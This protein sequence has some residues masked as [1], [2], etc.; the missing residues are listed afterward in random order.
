MFHCPCPGQM[1][2]LADKEGKVEDMPV[3][4]SPVATMIL[5]ALAG[6][7]AAVAVLLL[8]VR[9]PSLGM[10]LVAADTPNAVQ[11]AALS[12]KGPAQGEVA[13]GR[14]I[15]L[16]TAGLPEF[17]LLP[18]DLTDEPDTL[19]TYAAMADFFARQ[20]RIADALKQDRILVSTVDAQGV[21]HSSSLSP[22]PI[23]PVRDLPA[24]FWV[25]LLVGFASYLIGM[26][27]W[28]L[29]PGD[30]ATGLFALASFGILGFTFPA[31]LYSTRE[32]ALDGTFF[33]VLST[34]N[35]G[36]ALLFGAAM[37]ALLLRY[38]RPL[39]TGRWLTLPF[40][41][42]GLWWLA[43]TLRL[44][45]GPP[46]GAHL[47]TL[48]EMGGI[49]LCAGLQYWN[50]R[51]DPGARTVLRW[52]GLSVLV[53]A[54]GFVLT[55]IAP[56]MVGFAPLLPQ[57]YAFT[58][59]LLIHIG[60]A[61]GVVRYRLFDLDRWA[62]HILFYMVG[63][64]LLILLDAAL[65][66]LVSVGRAPAFGL[67]LLA[68]GLFYLPLRDS[69]ARRLSGRR[70]EDRE[71]WFQAMI[72]VAL[73]PSPNTQ[74]LRWRGLLETVFEP[75]R[76]FPGDDHAAPMLRDEGMALAMPAIGSL[77]PL[78]LEH[79]RKGR[80]LFTPYELGLAS[81]L[82]AMLIHAIGSRDAYERGVA[83]ERGRITRD[84]H[85]NI[86]VHLLGALHSQ[87]VERKDKLIRE[88]LGDL[89]DIINNSSGP[90]LTLEEHMADLRVEIADLL[91][92]AGIGFDWQFDLEGTDAFPAQAV[93]TLRAILREGVGNALRHAGASTIR[94]ALRHEG[95][96]TTLTIEDDGR[97]FDPATIIPG[98]GLNN[99][100]VRMAGLE[101]HVT[102][103]DAAP[104]TRIEARFP[105]EER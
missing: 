74:H 62:F 16:Q 49:L 94:I 79:A 10:E 58:F 73:T 98:N 104:G 12:P 88:T 20:S 35:H 9:Q 55:V 29:R 34:M 76:I 72:D 37:I 28:R 99:M 52:F 60:L 69:I 46:A 23:R 31:A 84:M 61:F 27:V 54:G 18:A 90:H 53:G 95:D 24:A 44:F 87:N 100:R 15:S 19:P 8:A 89:R 13:P 96:F 43:D 41:L 25:Q 50:A 6:L 1:A 68:I 4:L 80:R 63:A 51:G 2:V 86:G 30:P 36:G 64:V 47:P 56:S 48:I 42:F 82:H 97:G 103:T 70:A 83:E 3:R 66:S 81:E 22:A 101:G 32:L 33:R 5:L 71:K 57:G 17:I 93:P 59:F 75:L 7:A 26:W 105:L 91:S 14:L 102:I 67:S 78:R 85:D 38:P 11:V 21:A 45:D 92:S 39:V 77:P 65:I 40:A